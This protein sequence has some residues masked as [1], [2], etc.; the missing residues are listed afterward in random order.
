MGQYSPYHLRASSV[1][2]LQD[3]PQLIVSY[4]K[5][6][7]DGYVSDWHSHRRHQLIYAVEG[8]MMTQT[9]DV[10]WVVPAGYGFVVP[11][12]T[13]HRVIMKGEVHI[14]S[15]YIR[16]DADTDLNT[17][18]SVAEMPPL[19]VGLIDA[20]SALENRDPDSPRA[21]HLQHLILLELERAPEARLALPLGDDPR[22]RRV[23]ERLLAEPAHTGGIDHW[24]NVAGMSRRSFTRMFQQDMGMSFGQW[25]QRM[26]CQYALRAMAGGENREQIA[27]RL[28]YASK[29]ALEAMMRRVF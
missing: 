5:T 13:P 7:R 23:C 16:A 8:Q 29:Y 21:H 19:L 18:G 10:R 28:G 12:D 14:Q 9:S 17:R 20:F 27:A 15:L 6:Y 3:L 11:A 4:R 26:R 1:D 2:G 22:L 25:Q 24:A